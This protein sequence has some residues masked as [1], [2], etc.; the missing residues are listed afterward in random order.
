MSVPI[1][2]VIWEI[3]TPHLFVEQYCL[4]EVFVV[5]ATHGYQ[6]GRKFTYKELVRASRALAETYNNNNEG[7]HVANASSLSQFSSVFLRAGSPILPS[8][9]F[10]LDLST[11]FSTGYST[12][13]APG[14]A[15][16]LGILQRR[17]HSIPGRL[18]IYSFLIAQRI[19]SAS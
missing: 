6:Y 14:P 4:W 16:V 9:W 8:A 15:R 5:F 10:S 2:T 19:Y 17:S 11:L 3:T 18:R 13:Q 7:A 12:G 1:A